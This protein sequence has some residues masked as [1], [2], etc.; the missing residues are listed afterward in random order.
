MKRL[1]YSL[2][3]VATA[4]VP[5]AA[6]ALTRSYQ[7]NSQ[8]LLQNGPAMGNF[9]YGT[10]SGTLTYYKTGPANATLYVRECNFNASC[11]DRTISVSTTK[12]T[13]KFDA[14]FG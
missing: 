14:P 3:A 10:K 6:I 2:L 4:I 7:T 12:Q 8:K 1:T 11:S 13:Y 9:I 5:M